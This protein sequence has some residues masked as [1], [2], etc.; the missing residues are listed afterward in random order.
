MHTPKKRELWLDAAKGL[1]IIIVVWGHTVALG[2][3]SP[4]RHLNGMFWESF[5]IPKTSHKGTDPHCVN[6]LK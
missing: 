1:L 4:G 3:P 5:W 6:K 2:L